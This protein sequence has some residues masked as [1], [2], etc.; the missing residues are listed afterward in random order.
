MV[1]FSSNNKYKSISKEDTPCAESQITEK[2]MSV[3]HHTTTS[4]ITNTSDDKPLKCIEHMDHLHWKWPGQKQ[5]TMKIHR[6][7]FPGKVQGI[8]LVDSIM[9]LNSLPISDYRWVRHVTRQEW[10]TEKWKHNTKRKT[11]SDS[12]AVCGVSL[13]ECL[14]LLGKLNDCTAPSG[15]Q[16]SPSQPNDST[17]FFSLLNS[18]GTCQCLWQISCM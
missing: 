5:R 4:F 14:Q 11:N 10:R 9:V 2:W 16:G 6:A 13:P 17:F 8:F 3:V 12:S 7:Q 15:A 18:H 1:L